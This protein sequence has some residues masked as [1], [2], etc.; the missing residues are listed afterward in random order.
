MN[1][2]TGFFMILEFFL[3]FA[4]TC[5]CF[6]LGA[7]LTDDSDDH[8]D[9]NSLRNLLDGVYS[10]LRDIIK[11][12]ADRR[13]FS[14]DGVEDA[15]DGT[16]DPGARGRSTLNDDLIFA[17]GLNVG[18]S[19]FSSEDDPWKDF[20]EE[21]G[22]ENDGLNSANY[23]GA[24]FK[25]K[26]YFSR[27]DDSEQSDDSER[28]KKSDRKWA[29]PENHESSN[30]D[31]ASND[32]EEEDFDEDSSFD[33]YED[34]FDESYFTDHILDDDSMSYA[35]KVARLRDE[36][37]KGRHLA[38]VPLVYALLNY[39]EELDASSEK[40]A[41]SALDEAESLLSADRD[42]GDE[43]FFDPDDPE[44]Q[45]LLIYV[46][47]QRSIFCLKN[48][49]KPNIEA[50]NEALNRARELYRAYP[51]EDS[52]LLLARVYLVR[53]S[54]YLAN[55]LEEVAL[56]AFQKAYETV[57]GSEFD[58]ESEE[59]VVLTGVTLRS[60]AE[61]YRRIGDSQQ[62][63][64]AFREVVNYWKDRGDRDVYLSEFA[65]SAFHL[66]MTLQKVSPKESMEY[67]E[68][69]INAQERLY[70][71]DESQHAVELVF[72]MNI[73]ADL[74]FQR[75]KVEA[76]ALLDRSISILAQFL[77]QEPNAK[78]RNVA[79]RLATDSY[80]RRASAR[81]LLNHPI[82]SVVEDARNAIHSLSL[83]LKF[84][85][86]FNLRKPI[87][88]ILFFLI[89]TLFAGKN[90]SSEIFELIKYAELLYEQLS[91]SDKLY[92]RDRL[93]FIY[94]QAHNYFAFHEDDKTAFEMANRAVALIQS[95]DSDDLSVDD[96]E[97]LVQALRQRALYLYT[98]RR[99]S[100]RALDDCVAMMKILESLRRDDALDGTTA[101]VYVETL[102]RAAICSVIKEDLDE[103]R[104]Y[105]ARAFRLTLRQ[106]H[107]PDW[108]CQS[109][110]QAVL[111]AFYFSR[112]EGDKTTALRLIRL[113]LKIVKQMQ[114]KIL[115]S[116]SDL[117]DDQEEELL[118]D[119]Q[120]E[121]INLLER[122]AID[123]RLARIELLSEEETEDA[124]LLKV[125]GESTSEIDD[126]D[127]SQGGRGNVPY[128]Q[129]LL[130][131]VVFCARSAE[132]RA[133]E[134][135]DDAEEILLFAMRYLVRRL[136]WDINDPTVGFDEVNLSLKALVERLPERQSTTL[137]TLLNAWKS[138]VATQDVLKTALAGVESLQE[139]QD[140]SEEG[141][142]RDDVA[143]S[144]IRSLCELRAEICA[145]VLGTGVIP[146]LP[147]KS[148]ETRDFEVAFL[149]EKT[150]DD[151]AIRSQREGYLE[152][153]DARSNK[154]LQYS[155]A[156][157]KEEWR[158]RGEMSVYAAAYASGETLRYD[159]ES[160]AR[161]SKQ[162]V[163]LWRSYAVVRKKDK[164]LLLH[165]FSRDLLH[166]RYRKLPSLLA[167]AEFLFNT[168][169]G[170]Y[171]FLEVKAI[172]VAK[173][174][175]SKALSIYEA[176]IESF[177]KLDRY[178]DYVCC[179]LLF[180]LASI[181]Q[182]EHNHIEENRTLLKALRVH[183][184]LCE[185]DNAVEPQLLNRISEEIAK[186]MPMQTASNPR[187][188]PRAVNRFLREVGKIDAPWLNEVYVALHPLI[189]ELVDLYTS[190]VE[191]YE[192]SRAAIDQL[193]ASTAKYIESLEDS[194]IFYSSNVTKRLARL[195]E[196]QI[197]FWTLYGSFDRSVLHIEKSLE[198]IDDIQNRISAFHFGIL[199]EILSARKSNEADDRVIAD[200]HGGE[201]GKDETKSFKI[202]EVEGE[203][204]PSDKLVDGQ[205]S[206]GGDDSDADSSES[207][208]DARFINSFVFWVRTKRSLASRKL[209]L[210]WKTKPLEV[211][212]S[213]LGNEGTTPSL[214]EHKRR[215]VDLWS[216]MPINRELRDYVIEC[217]ALNVGGLKRIKNW[218]KGA[219]SKRP[220]KFIASR[221]TLEELETEILAYF[222]EET[223]LAPQD[224]DPKATLRIFL[225]RFFLLAKRVDFRREF[226][227]EIY[228]VCSVYATR[229]RLFSQGINLAQHALRNLYGFED[230]QRPVMEGNVS[231][232]F[233]TKRAALSTLEVEEHLCRV[234]LARG[235]KRDVLRAMKLNL[236][237]LQLAK[238]M[239]SRGWF[240]AQVYYVKMCVVA[241]KILT[242][243]NSL[244]EAREYA[245]R[246]KEMIRKR[247]RR[248]IGCWTSQIQ[249]DLCE[250]DARLKELGGD[251]DNSERVG[252]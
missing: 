88:I 153:I 211:E 203:S 138:D 50:V 91:D 159:F 32:D 207:D 58:G 27:E 37:E 205:G 200:D 250:I 6:A 117:G 125:L 193:N 54:V 87:F 106:T 38:R 95:D 132:R 192:I 34:D 134:G 41:M 208:D 104:S 157:S 44:N 251:V 213:E 65:T 142:A 16:R 108:D 80:L 55:E 29:R 239:I 83:G 162:F 195:F 148:P 235:R 82:R 196:M 99:D 57:S 61:A 20:D 105:I 19:L 131:D 172:P 217:F 107:Y 11:N 146:N 43:E 171:F 85:P 2:G 98:V 127:K 93:T 22:T 135:I 181:F 189:F 90:E 204:Q 71:F 9:E 201:E 103:A 228:Y 21:S 8:G 166:V 173:A 35:Q 231:K 234:Y 114:I 243:Q 220:T 39:V 129:A 184:R 56:N 241:A 53:G 62:E 133:L 5:G 137:Q 75:H 111:C 67:L 144:C 155:G 145:G 102:C 182:A 3:T 249:T 202:S 66:A 121:K 17:D 28:P 227:A 170:E 161:Y 40:D 15:A 225:E 115:E 72:Y 109:L 164:S 186:F 219:F 33:S 112:N 252:D 236:D 187:A 176:H 4:T 152:R 24:F 126:S 190:D 73:R 222:V 69:A 36:F 42:F 70:S 209:Y 59:R 226:L 49:L 48:D 199:R 185:K 26:N 130:R 47:L 7:M 78:K 197:Q 242:N 246:A 46:L 77:E 141:D 23:F 51:V 244:Q 60:L 113:A 139:T 191:C 97:A 1:N 64:K 237:G 149:R 143:T 151:F 218:F 175:Y 150:N 110:T 45:K 68:E 174:A 13:R 86:N 232:T 18:N 194:E 136:S 229:R 179:S 14:E 76:L 12:L 238:K 168:T 74:L 230:L 118:N 180:R 198:F 233:S 248:G 63:L 177:K 223:I 100:A 96:R 128:Y 116:D 212:S 84:D 10:E 89:K 178:I 154:T 79:F 214:E 122:T 221:A 25:K 165:V 169:L 123:F 163:E 119:S 188:I 81:H 224:Q 245:N 94:L 206:D 30:Q 160:V 140:F 247:T 52:Q 31:E 210:L 156:P 120:R 240:S 158:R 183:L 167:A 124:S 215:F 216:N 147:T 101:N 92:V